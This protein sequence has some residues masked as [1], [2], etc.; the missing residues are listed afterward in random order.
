M[1]KAIS[2]EV[3][4][5]F[6]FGGLCLAALITSDKSRCAHLL[7][8]GIIS[9]WANAPMQCNKKAHTKINPCKEWFLEILFQSFKQ[10]SN[11]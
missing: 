7:L 9:V 2:E 1:G 10:Q 8:S 6:T 3:F 4:S 5:D 11:L